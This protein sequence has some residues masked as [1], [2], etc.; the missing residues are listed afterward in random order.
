MKQVKR[1]RWEIRQRERGIVESR[2]LNHDGYRGNAVFLTTLENC[3]ITPLK[4]PY[5][6]SYTTNDLCQARWNP[7]RYGRRAWR[8][9]AK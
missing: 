8:C 6:V 1:Y 7:V 4:R 9:K 3:G 2:P 5:R